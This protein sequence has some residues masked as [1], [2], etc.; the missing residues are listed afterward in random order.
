[1][2]NTNPEIKHYLVTGATGTLGREIVGAL[3][4]R[5]DTI[6]YAGYRN[7]H[8]FDDIY[9]EHL[10]H[11]RIRP[12]EIDVASPVSI[13]TAASKLREGLGGASLTALVN[14]AGGIIR[15]AENKPEGPA[16]WLDS[17]IFKV[18]CLGP[19]ALALALH[20][21]EVVVKRVVNVSSSG[22]R[23]FRPKFTQ[24][25]KPPGPDKQYNMAKLG[26]E[27]GGRAL[28][29]KI[30]GV[31][32][33]NAVPGT[34]HGGFFE[35]QPWWLRGIDH[36]VGRKPHVAAKV[37]MHAITESVPTNATVEPHHMAMFGEPIVNLG[38]M[39]YLQKHTEAPGLIMDMAEGFLALP[40]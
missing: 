14:N 7:A 4:A 9:P 38:T 8:K 5:S 20:R 37:V 2:P 22:A 28:A 13:R 1:M 31:T 17:T 32:I 21:E 6:V 10:R 15:A 35:G 3:A 18:N 25:E 16:S 34:I 11:G 30:P 29:D 27:A 12:L 36:I 24:D 19:L 23:L 39:P 40:A 26:L 33:V